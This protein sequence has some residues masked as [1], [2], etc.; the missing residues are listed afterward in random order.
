MIDALTVRALGAELEALLGHGRVQ[1]VMLVAPLTIGFEVYAR[2]Q[3]RY[4]LASAEQNRPRLYLVGE[5]LRRAPGTLTPFVLLLKK[6]ATGAFINRIEVVPRERILRIEFDHAEHGISTLVVEMMGRHSNLILLDPGGVILDAAR[7]V[8]PSVNRVRAIQPR[9]P[10][11]SPPPQ[12]KADP[13]ALD[14]A[15]L[16]HLLSGANGAT[17][18]E[19]LV[20]T[21][22]GTSPLLARELAYRAAGA[23]D[24]PFDS[25][26]VP[27]LLGELQR[28]WTHP[29]EPTLAFESDQLAGSHAEYRRAT[30]TSLSPRESPRPVAVAAYALTHLPHT[31]SVPTMSLALERFFGAEESYETVKAPYRQQLL[32]VLEKLERTRASLSREWVSAEEVERIRQKGEL[33]LAYQHQLA[34][35]QTRLRAEVGDGTVLEI[36]LDPTRSVVENAQ[37]YFAEYRRA[38]DA[39]ARVPERLAVVESEIAY[40]EQ[41][42]ADLEMA[43]TRA[44]I[45][46]VLAEAR[47]EN[48]LRD[49]HGGKERAVARSSTEPRVFT[50]PDGFQVLVGRNARQNDA[51]T[52]GR[53]KPED[54]WLHARERAGAHVVILNNGAPVPETTL[55]FAGALAAYY[56]SARD[57]T[58]VDVIVTPRKNVRRIAGAPRP[59]L[60]TVRAE[61]VLRVRPS[62]P[63][64]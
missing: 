55:H 39:R 58:W 4:L 11:L 15:Q 29:P 47:A 27:R 16:L 62:L 24:A 61:R 46:D 1:A 22:A 28:V 17:L 53:A 50:S 60:V 44:E 2:R 45:E 40:V 23:A 31:E 41:I 6:Y 35:G 7:R 37:R 49:V 21:I 9:V 36:E 48:L 30:D 34:P 18:A 14:A 64:S 19:R 25:A 43:E 10:Y 33:L 52:F 63:E 13:L 59:G 42:I 51:L 57:E 5:K 38:K 12:A 3:R 26:Y 32:A 54:L 8:P 56:S 20:Q